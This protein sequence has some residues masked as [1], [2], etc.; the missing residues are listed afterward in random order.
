MSFKNFLQRIISENKFVID[1]KEYLKE[2]NE[3]DLVDLLNVVK[4]NSHIGY[5]VFKPEHYQSQS[6]LKQL[7]GDIEKQ[8][9]QNNK[10][11]KTFTQDKTICLLAKITYN[12]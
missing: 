5:V 8:L 12:W 1:L 10:D 7:R 11:Y 3:N 6:T 9:V 4:E 2:V